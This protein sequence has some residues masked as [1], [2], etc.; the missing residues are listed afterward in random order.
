MK[1]CPISKGEFEMKL[2]KLQ[3]ESNSTSKDRPTQP[4]KTAADLEEEVRR[5]AYQLY[6]QRGKIDG[7]EVED[8]LEAE[9]EFNTRRAGKAA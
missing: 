8:W 1:K 6:E 3:F 9:A 7:F 5:R 2:E 4:L